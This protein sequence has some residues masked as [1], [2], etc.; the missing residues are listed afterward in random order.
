MS[1]STIKFSLSTSSKHPSSTSSSSATSKPK[2]KSVFNQFNDDD[3]DEQETKQAQ[4]NLQNQKNKKNSHTLMP[5]V[6]ISSSKLSRQ[7]KLAQEEATK[8]DSTI[9]EYDQVYDFMKLADSKAKLEKE[10]K[11]AERKVS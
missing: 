1:S 4:N 5:V 3:A 8:L 11:G 9:F 7:Q 10:Q 2:P 6:P